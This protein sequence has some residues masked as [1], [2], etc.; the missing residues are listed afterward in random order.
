[1][2]TDDQFVQQAKSK[3]IAAV[4]VL[5]HRDDWAPAARAQQQ[6]NHGLIRVM[7]TLEYVERSE[8]MLVIQ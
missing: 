7:P 5:E 3:G 2:R 8:R 4:Q 1:L 6:A